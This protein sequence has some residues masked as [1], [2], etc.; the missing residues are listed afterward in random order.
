[1]AN[2]EQNAT[3][4]TVNKDKIMAESPSG[5][6]SVP[7]ISSETP[8]AAHQSRDETKPN[9]KPA[10]KKKK[11]VDAID[12]IW[13]CTEC[14]EA[15]CDADREA[16]LMI[17]EGKCN[18]P[19]HYPCANLSSPPSSEQ[20]WICDD[21]QKERHRCAFCEEYGTDNDEVFCCDKEDCGL[22]FHESCLSMQ[23]VEIHYVDENTSDKRDQDVV[24]AEAAIVGKAHFVCPA[25]SCWAC[26][27]DYVPPEDDGEEEK[28]T[29]SQKKKGK[30][31]KKKVSSS[32]AQKR[33]PKLYVSVF[34][35][36][37]SLLNSILTIVRING[38]VL[39]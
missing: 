18:R 10:A 5:A 1:M 33:D 32:F 22:F 24:D 3:N 39:L 29:T 27:E 12:L 23:N 15:E 19:F 28:T 31:R 8:R 25:H 4:S 13:I 21:C 26:T 36:V 14:N 30:G 16:D 20:E 17:C 2:A 37:L 9:A 34:A 35:V 6:S 7:S 11:T 38:L